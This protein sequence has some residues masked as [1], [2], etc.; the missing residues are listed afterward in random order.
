MPYFIPNT[1]LSLRVGAVS[2]V[3]RGQVFGIRKTC[4]P[5]WALPLVRCMTLDKVF[6]L[7]GSVSSSVKW[8]ALKITL[9]AGKVL[10]TTLG[11][12]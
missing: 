6:K 8:V 12:L 4:D 10:N 5:G 11:T 7:S 9:N 3:V 1:V 2:T